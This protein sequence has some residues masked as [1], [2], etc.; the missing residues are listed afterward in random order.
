[1]RSRIPLISFILVLSISACTSAIMME[2]PL[3]E[4]GTPPLPTDTPTDIYI[5]DATGREQVFS[6]PPERIVF[7]GRG[8]QLLIHAAYLYPEVVGRIVGV[9]QRLQRGVSMLSLVDPRLDENTQLERDASAEQIA[10]VHPDVVLMKTYMAERLGRSLEQLDIPV[11]YLELE[12]PEQFLR[13]VAMLGLLLGNPHRTNEVLAFYQ[14][15]LDQ[16]EGALLDIGVDDRPRVLLIQYDS[17]SGEIAFRVPSAEWLQTRIVEM[18]GGIPVWKEAVISGGWTIVS[19]EQIAVWDPDKIILIDYFNDPNLA[20]AELVEDVKWQALSA[21]QA[22]ELYAFPGDF[23]SWDQPDPRWIL[24]L[25]WLAAVIHP[26]RFA[27]IDLLSDVRSFYEDLYGI[28]AA[29]FE[30]EILPLITGDL[31]G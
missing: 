7:A 27:D 22:G 24:G 19:F 13:D 18:A 9:E 10:P 12:T 11:I 14:A 21:V 20:T 17:R 26:D 16:V 31:G 5:T 6:A 2:T 30:T 15:R 28:D 23:L 29:I 8:S 25:Q 4:P 1:M 3:P